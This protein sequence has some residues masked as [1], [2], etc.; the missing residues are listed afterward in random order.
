M[1]VPADD[2]TVVGA[3]TPEA[4]LRSAP[5]CPDEANG[6][7]TDMDSVLLGRRAVGQR[8]LLE[9]LCNDQVRRWRRGLRVPVEAYL[10]LHPQLR[11]DVEGTFELIYNEFLLREELGEPPALDEFRW[12]FPRFVP[13]LQ[14][15]VELHDV[16]GREEP[17]DAAPSEPTVHD[18]SGATDG[19]G[20]GGRFIAPGYRLMGEL[21]RGGMGAVY[22]AWQVRLKRV[23][24]VKL[25]R[26][27]AYAD[28][29]AA[30]RFQAEAEAA[31][32][33]QHPNIVPVFEV[34][35]FEGMGYLVLEYAA[36]GGLDRRFAGALQPPEDSARLIETLARAIHY[37]H[38]RG[39]I[40]RDLKPANVLLT[41]DGVPKITDFG[42]A[43]L[44]EREEGLTRAGEIMGTPSYMA[45][46]QVAGLSDQVTSA[47]DVYALGAILYEALTGRPPFK[48]TTPLSTLEQVARQEPLAPGKLQRHLP[49]D[50]ETICLKCLE[51]EPSRRYPS[52]HELADDLNRYL[53]AQPIRARPTPPW[54][55]AWKWARRRPSVAAA[56]AALSVALITLLG[57]G[58]YYNARLRHEMTVAVH[59]ERVA[60]AN[61]QVA[62]D[63]RN[64]AL[65]A[66]GVAAANAQVANDQRNLALKALNQL[67]YEVQEKLA[68]TYATRSLRQG[69]LA[70]AIAGL[71]EIGQSAVGAAPDLSQAVAHQKI[72]DIFRIIG[73]SDTARQHYDRARRL[74]STAQAPARGETGNAEV[75]Y[76]T[77]MGLGLLAIRAQQ[78]DAA[79]SDLTR[80]VMMAES[81]VGNRPREPAARRDLIEAYL[82]LG[83][84]YSFALEYTAAETWFRKMQGQAK[85]WVDEEPA[86][87]QAR[88]LLASSHR[89]LGD[90]RKFSANYAAARQEY[91]QAIEIVEQLLKR[92]PEN[93]EYQMHL[94]IAL[95]D[96]GGIAVSQRRS[97][98][99]GQL[100]ERAERLFS[101]LARSDPDNLETL[102][103]L[104]HTKLHFARLDRAE[105]RFAR[106][107]DRFR[108]VRSRLRALERDGRL[109]GRHASFPSEGELT[110]EIDACD[111]GARA[112]KAPE[113]GRG[114]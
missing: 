77:H 42:L 48:G 64:L 73:R 66:E 12:R 52:A 85:R 41:E 47:T 54:E 61:A 49:R 100:F 44:L 109:E 93:F 13:R 88:D 34:G 25:I 101:D 82:Q 31:A 108:Q 17:D 3:L 45:P 75:L 103:F 5:P 67:I 79:R 21:G 43:K 8:E 10:S 113:N 99:A 104:I 40:H 46:E 14:R 16:L 28:T 7:P 26:A 22:K 76:Q 33:F 62:N 71:D 96:L 39:I 35:E 50:I 37:A 55:R 32:R 20:A 70:T 110:A 29:G 2:H 98:E 18:E 56:L 90:L 19:P 84:A 36:G 63:Q 102:Q 94:A 53:H 83:R 9:H 57:G 60:A 86:S 4:G 15:Q 80:A 30:A 97:D 78:F 72:G 87:G 24:A 65:K 107:A 112:A 59:A 89:K 38:Q 69:L 11:D 6:G 1:S 111:A 27:D 51:K 23:V 114:S 92:D 105:H 95:D 58:F 106:A 91:Q 81:I 68:P 74:A